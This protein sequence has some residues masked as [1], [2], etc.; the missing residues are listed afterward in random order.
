[1]PLW[2]RRVAAP[3]AD[4]RSSSKVVR[5]H[6]GGPTCKP[7]RSRLLPAV[8][9]FA[10]L[11][12]PVVRLRRQG[13]RQPTSPADSI[14]PFL[15]GDLPLGQW[16]PDDESTGD[17]PWQSF[18]RARNALAGGQP[19]VAVKLWLSIA[20]TTNLE[21]RQTLQAWS[22]LRRQGM[23]PSAD[24]SPVVHGVICEIAVGDGHDVLAIYKDGSSRYLN[25]SGRIIVAQGGPPQSAL[26]ANA[27]ITAA[28]PLGNVIGLWDQPTLPTVPSGHARL[29]LLTPG[30]FRFGQGPQDALWQEPMAGPVISAA[31]QLL[32]ILTESSDHPKP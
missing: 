13:P 25:H 19:D 22:F 10:G 21:S 16:P 2:E 32:L 31:T 5:F 9:R 3:A 30:G 18:I 24:E 1:M 7:S 26:A 20:R 23:A 17:E 28:E 29:L 6:D 4:I 12:L 11:S 14:R 15:Y 8:V 27:V